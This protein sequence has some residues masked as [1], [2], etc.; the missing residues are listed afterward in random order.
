MPKGNNTV[1]P[2]RNSGD[3]ICAVGAGT[4]LGAACV[5]LP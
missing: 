4:N 5:V 3:Y 2:V 1:Y